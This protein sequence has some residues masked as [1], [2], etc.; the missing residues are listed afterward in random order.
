MSTP[1]VS[2]APSDKPNGILGEEIDDEQERFEIVDLPIPDVLIHGDPSSEFLEDE[3]GYHTDDDLSELEDIE[4]ESSKQTS[5]RRV[6]ETV[7][8]AF[9]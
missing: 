7:A 3:D 1:A 8:R 2:P 9:D 6:P 4:L 5:H